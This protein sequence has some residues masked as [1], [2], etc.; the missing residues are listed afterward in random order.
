[1]TDHLGA[2]PEERTDERRGYRNG[3]YRRKLTTR[4]GRLELEVPPG[5]KGEF[6]T[7]LFQ[8]QERSEKALVLALMQQGPPGSLRAPREGD[9]HRA[10]RTPV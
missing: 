4:V 10:V 7:V 1:M 5:R 9:H 6:Q 3:S 2:G 8:R